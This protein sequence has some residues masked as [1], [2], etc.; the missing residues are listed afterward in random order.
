MNNFG[1]S[2]VQHGEHSLLQGI[3]INNNLLSFHKPKSCQERIDL[4]CSYPI[5]TLERKLQND[6][7]DDCLIVVI[8]HNVSYTL[9]TL[10]IYMINT[11]IKQKIKFIKKNYQYLLLLLFNC[12]IVSDSAI[13]RLQHSRIPCPRLSR[14]LLKFMTIESV[15]QP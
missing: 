9:N 14:N 1:G 13:P 15:I 12:Q 5:L 3:I 11:Q 10:S 2:N 7:C 4:E 6:V 8:F